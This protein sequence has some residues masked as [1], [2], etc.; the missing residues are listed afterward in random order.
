MS[1]ISDRADRLVS[2][3][4][5]KPPRVVPPEQKKAISDMRQRLQAAREKVKR[6]A[7]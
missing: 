4:F 5:K 1:A 7:M 2:K 3:T 6:G